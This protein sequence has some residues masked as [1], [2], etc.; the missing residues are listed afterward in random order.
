M[1]VESHDG[2]IHDEDM[3]I[4]EMNSTEMD[5]IHS[6]KTRR[7]A[8]GMLPQ[9]LCGT[10]WERTGAPVRGVI[11]QSVIC[12]VLIMYSNFEFLL[13]ASTL[14][15]CTTLCLE[16]GAFLRLRY[17]EP[18]TERPYTVPGGLWTAWLITVDKWFLVAVLFM[19]VGMENVY[20]VLYTA[21]F[22]VVTM[23]YYLLYLPCRPRGGNGQKYPKK[24]T[25][26]MSTL[27]TV[28]S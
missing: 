22:V 6:D 1:Y 7:I 23:I 17:T 11:L 4:V 5:E 3:E 19:W 10:I 18:E 13:Q 15:N 9:W 14:I 26:E 25:W 16:M 12:S 21:G 20:Y 28:L 2:H 27:S 8:I 24:S